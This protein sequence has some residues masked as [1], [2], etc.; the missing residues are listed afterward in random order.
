MRHLRAPALAVLLTACLTGPDVGAAIPGGGLPSLEP[1]L[2]S[3]QSLVFSPRCATA[4]CHVGGNGT[5]LSLVAGESFGA[6]VGIPSEQAPAV[7][8]V[9]PGDLAQSYLVIKLRGTHEAVG[10]YGTPMPPG[11][12]ELTAEELLAIEGWVSAGAA[13]D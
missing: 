9:T 1:T 8:L 6:L 2:S 7:P 5:P 11:G 13:D 3:V 12:E 10:G 4:A